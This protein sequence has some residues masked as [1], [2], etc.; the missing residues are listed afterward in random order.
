MVFEAYDPALDRVVAVKLLRSE[1]GLPG[2]EPLLAARLMRE[3]RAA[4]RVEHPNVI[5]IYDVGE[6]DGIVFVAMERLYGMDLRRWLRC[7]PRPW[8]EILRVF[9]AA[10]RGLEAVHEAGLVHRDFKPSNVFVDED[11]RVRLL[12]F[13]LTKVAGGWASTNHD[14][15]AEPKLARGPAVTPLTAP[16]EVLGT[17]LYM[18]PEQHLGETVGPAADQFAFCASM[19]EALCGVPAF[20]GSTAGDLHLAKLWERLTPAPRSRA[21]RALWAVLRRG[22]RVEP[23]ARWPDIRTLRRALERCGHPRAR[24]GPLALGVALLLGG[25]V[26][27]GLARGREPEPAAVVDVG[28]GHEPS[29]P[30]GGPEDRARALLREARD[31]EAEGQPHEAL[32]VARRAR[33]VAHRGVEPSLW[34]EA[35]ML[36]VRLASPEQTPAQQVSAYEAL[37]FEAVEHE[38]STEA[39]VAAAN[40]VYLHGVASSDPEEALRWSEHARTHL[41]RLKPGARLIPLEHNTGVALRHAG[42]LA[43]AREHLERAVDLGRRFGTPSDRAKSEIDLAATL[44]ALGEPESAQRLAQGALASLEREHGVD[45]PVLVPALQI[46]SMGQ[47]AAAQWGAAAETLGRALRLLRQTSSEPSPTLVGTQVRLALAEVRAG[48]VTRARALVDEAAALLERGTLDATVT[49]L[50]AVDLA[51]PLSELQE[52]ERIVATLPDDIRELEGA[53]AWFDAALIEAHLRL[54]TSALALGDRPEARRRVGLARSSLGRARIE[55]EARRVA[56][57]LRIASLRVG[58][59]GC[60][61]GGLDSSAIDGL[62]FEEL[63]PLERAELHFAAARC[64]SGST[65]AHEAEAALGVLHSSSPAALELS[66]RIQRWIERCSR[67]RSCYD[68]H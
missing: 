20:A 1:Q 57:E 42:Q 33:E 68:R 34:V 9:V 46:V 49:A 6:A 2:N 23:G 19:Y 50:L 38:R 30:A 58:L 5:E 18:A 41:E 12:D 26:S 39:A 17:P 55:P 59:E 44:H 11:G 54:A 61:P 15:R 40:L 29:E 35:S 37:F 65:S 27:V 24:K 25:G 66:R 63:G 45:D 64:E 36:V 43:R 67:A 22:L 7:G 53:G 10:A 3:A 28:P 60:A 4:S 13:G 62:R 48:H 51:L 8:R 31:L 21:P 14:P 52:H 32:I 56:L 16:G 47:M